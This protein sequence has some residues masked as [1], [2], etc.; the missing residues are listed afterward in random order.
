M[1]PDG[2]LVSCEWLK[3]NF[4]NVKVLDASWYVKGMERS[5]G[6]KFDAVG[7]F[8]KHLIPGFWFL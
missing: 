7:D 2:L 5:P 6:V 4:A 8:E 1:S 3:E